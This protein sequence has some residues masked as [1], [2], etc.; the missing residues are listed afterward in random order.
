MNDINHLLDREAILFRMS[1]AIM[2]EYVLGWR[3]HLGNADEP[4][5]RECMQT[6]PAGTCAMS[7]H[8]LPRIIQFDFTLVKQE[9][10]NQTYMVLVNACSRSMSIRSAG[11]S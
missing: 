1:Q 4:P 9:L 10:H 5:K 2:D 3:H 11:E 6:P 8:Q 7:R